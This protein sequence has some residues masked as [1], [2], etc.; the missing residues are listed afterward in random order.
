M[1]QEN[2]FDAEFYPTSKEIIYEMLKPYKHLAGRTILEPSAGKGDIIDYI[3]EREDHYNLPAMYCIEKD[4]NLQAILRDKDYKLISEDFLQYNGDYYFD[5]ILMNPPFSNG[6]EHLLHAWEILK[7]GD[8]VCLLNKETYYNTYSEKRKL[9]KRIIDENGE[10]EDL[11][12]CF[13]WDVERKA[14]CEV[15]IVRLTKESKEGIFDFDFDKINDEENFELN[16]DSFNDKIQLRDVIGN[17]ELQYKK[18]KLAFIDKLKAEDGMRFYSIGLTTQ[19]SSI[20][21]LKFNNEPIKKRYNDFLDAMKL[22]I[23]QKVIN[24]MGMERYMTSSVRENFQKFI[25]QQGAMDFTRE[26]VFSMINMLFANTDNILNQAILDVFDLFT[27]YHKEN[28]CH[29]EGWKTNDMWKV[30]KRIILPY[31]IT[32]G[33]YSTADYLKIHG[34]KFSLNYTKRSENSDIDKVMCHLTGTKYE[35]CFTLMNSLDQRFEFLGQVVTGEKYDNT[36]ESE[37]FTWKFYKKGTLHI[38]FKDPKLWEKFNL[39]ACKGKNWLPPEY[40]KAI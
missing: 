4:K 14:H 15:I 32:Y 40:K 28:R 33:E 1:V 6:D 10:V 9:L 11:G 26:N 36:G 31:W 18:L 7:E 39:A 13:M 27:K 38:E 20:E 17:M 2:L 35:D 24:E 25:I 37:F 5:L 16:E 34:S 30:N 3:I 12:K 23:W 8:I 19:Y 21:E 22:E 29:V